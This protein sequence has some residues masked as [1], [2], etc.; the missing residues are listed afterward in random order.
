MYRVFTLTST[1]LALFSTSAMAD[2][3]LDLIY[4]T[5][6]L[7]GGTQITTSTTGTFHLQGSFT[8]TGYSSSGG[9][10]TLTIPAGTISSGTNTDVYFVTLSGTFTSGSATVNSSPYS[11]F[12]GLSF[13]FMRDNDM[14]PEPCLQANLVP[15][16]DPSSISSA[17]VTVD[18]YG[19]FN[20]AGGMFSSTYVTT[21]DLFGTYDST[22]VSS[23][24]PEPADF[25]AFSGLGALGLLFLRRRKA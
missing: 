21:S 5:G 17:P 25:A 18:F 19:T 14:S 7:T 6:T 10:Y 16:T 4:D 24:V 2:L 12:T 11:N 1:I 3:T 8:A 13:I 22:T 20:F 15:S 9:A 23:S